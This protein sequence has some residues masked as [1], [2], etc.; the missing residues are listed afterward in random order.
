MIEVRND[1]A[2]SINS[3]GTDRLPFPLTFTAREADGSWQIS[4]SAARAGELIDLLSGSAN[5]TVL[6]WTSRRTAS[7][8][9]TT[10]SGGPH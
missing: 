8:T 2:F 9:R 3:V 1:G 4:A 10:G 7:C 6:V 5:D